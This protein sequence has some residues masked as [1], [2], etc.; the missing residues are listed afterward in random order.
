MERRVWY[1]VPLVVWAESLMPGPGRVPAKGNSFAK[2]Q[3][4]GLRQEAAQGTA[5]HPEDLMKR[6]QMSEP[7]QSAR[8]YS[9]D[10][11]S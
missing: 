11:G 5:R 7:E 6:P 3:R 1:E 2:G 4:K 10:A 8:R 9:D